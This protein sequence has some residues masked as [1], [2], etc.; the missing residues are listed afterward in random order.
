VCVCVC[1]C[2]CACALEW[3]VQKPAWLFCHV[4]A[5]LGVGSGQKQ[6]YG[7]GGAHECWVG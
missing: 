1:V 2:V 3:A 6:A 7:M 4:R 5:C